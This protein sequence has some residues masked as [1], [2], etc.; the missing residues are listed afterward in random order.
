MNGARLGSARSG[1]LARAVVICVGLAALVACGRQQFEAWNDGGT[2]ASGSSGAGGGSG[3]GI[4]NPSSEGGPGFVLDATSPSAD[5]SSPTSAGGTLV[6]SRALGSVSEPDCAGCTFPGPTAPPCA[7]SAPPITIVYPPDA[8]LVPP[9]MNIMSVQWVPYGAAYQMFSVD[10]SNPPNTDWHIVTKCS[11]QTIDAQSM[12]PSGGCE[13]SL[14]PLSWSR[15]AGANRGGGPVTISVRGT[16]DGSCATSSANQI[17]WSIAEEDLLGTYYYWKS[18][19]SS[20]GVGGQI[21]K[22]TF[23]DLNMMEQDVTSQSINATCNGCH[24]LSRDGTRMV[25]Y[26]DDDDSD[27]EYSDIAGSYLDMT[28][29]PATELP[30]GVTQG[31]HQ[32]GGQ[33]AGF[34]TIDPNVT[35]LTSATM[36]GYYITSNGYPCSGTGNC[37]SATSGYTTAVPLNGFS[38]WNGTNG[39]FINGVTISA[40]G[41]RPTMPDWGPDGT[42]VVYVVPQGEFTSWRKDDAHIFGGSLWT[43]PYAGNGSFGPSPAEI[44]HSTGENNYY[45]SYSPDVNPTSFI[46]FNRVVNM[47]QGA[48][49]NSGFC[50]DDSFSNPVARLML[51]RTAAGSTP[52]DLEK[53]NGS[54]LT[55]PVPLSNSYPR[56]A[57]FVQTYKGNKLLWFT[58]S[59]TRDYGVRVLNHKSGMY[60]CYPADAAETPGATHKQPFASQCQEP[61][62]WMAPLSFSEAQGN[63][64]PSGVAFWIPYQDITTH[65]HTA[66]WTQQHLPPPPPPVDAGTPCMCQ[67][68]TYGACGAA[69][70]GCDCCTG[71]GYCTG[72]NTCFSPPH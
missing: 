38:V 35:A 19:I 14:D 31:G 47:S 12:T 61:Q 51:L 10:F 4:Q 44:L 55:S 69:N 16:T 25:V 62:L 68:A 42:S 65:N 49:C 34:S 2:P 20:N 71:N 24:S 5:T 58:F 13:V 60:Q 56:W 11:G 72:S 36:P 15:L 39:S 45:P 17:H 46:I 41:T 29:N 40:S 23:G 30:G 18:T 9:N 66:Q 21:W 7:S 52:I 63:R 28:T 22:K 8:V 27:D 64:D 32:G 67:S 33:P 48:N 57:P 50:P 26:S 53:A 59:S 1:D 3:T 37:G 6:V 43:I 70:G 54:P